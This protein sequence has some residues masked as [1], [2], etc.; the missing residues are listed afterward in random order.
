MSCTLGVG[1]DVKPETLAETTF[2]VFC[3]LFG[4][5]TWAFIVGGATTALAGMDG[6]AVH[7]RQ[8][9]DTMNHCTRPQ[10]KAATPTFDARSDGAQIRIDVAWPGGAQSCAIGAYPPSFA[11]R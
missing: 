6:R 1:L 9:M 5:F 10:T 11:S 2:S 7:Q 4:S 3:C 8:Q